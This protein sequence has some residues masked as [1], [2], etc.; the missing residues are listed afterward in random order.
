MSKCGPITLDLDRCT[1]CGAC[2]KTC[3]TEVFRIDEK[4]A[5]AVIVHP[6]DCHVCFLCVDDC[7]TSA[8]EIDFSLAN[9]RRH[10]TYEALP[11]EMLVFDPKLG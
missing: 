3:P 10:S 2:V 5:K 1:G 8:I 9:P 7:P 4:R 11:D 6:N